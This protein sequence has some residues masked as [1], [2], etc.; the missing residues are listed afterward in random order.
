M[1]K[2]ST[3]CHPHI[4]AIFNCNTTKISNLYVSK[5]NKTLNSSHYKRKLLVNMSLPDMTM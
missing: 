5:V 2:Y 1:E 4:L 3:F